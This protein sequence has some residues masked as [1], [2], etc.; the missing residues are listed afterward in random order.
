LQ[1]SQ[2]TI[3]KQLSAPDLG[4]SV[5]TAQASRQLRSQLHEHFGFRRFRPGQAEAI[6]SAMAGNDTLVIM[7]TGSGKSLCFQLPALTLE[8]HTVVVS[9]LIA[10]MKDQADAL[11]ERGISVAVMNSTLSVAEE[12]EANENI[13][14]GRYEFIYTTPERLA[15]R[16]F[17]SLLARHPIDLFVVDEAHCVSQWGHSFRPEYLLIGDAIKHLG[18][19]PVL[20]LTATAT[21]EVI[22]DIQTQLGIPSAEIVHTGFYRSNLNLSVVHASGDDEKQRHLLELLANNDGSG[23]IYT[24]TV[25]AVE[26]LTTALSEQGFAV[27]AYHGRLAARKRTAAQDRFMN[28]E[29]KAIVATNAFGLGIDKPDIRFVIHYHFPGTI[30]AFYQEFGRAGRDGL[31]ANCTL[32]YDEHDRRLQ[33]FFQAGAYPREDDLVNAHHALALLS[34]KA[35]ELSLKDIHAGS[36]LSCSKMKVCLALFVNR[37]IVA[38]AARGKYRLVQRE[39]TREQLARAGQSYQERRERDLLRLEQMMQYSTA[40]ACRWNRILDYF[41][42]GVLSGDSCGHCDRCK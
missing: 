9:P 1:Y 34:D 35:T 2:V 41:D 18:H 23:I 10:L 5:A 21:S 28:G 30:D 11:R 16:E 25:K 15:S 36:P 20:A 37:G 39:M 27:D 19:P 12:K 14:A 7:P 17:Q 33:R 38:Q 4:D 32:L 6:E 29:L 42:S 3:A 40:S 13:A 26:Q 31:P 8:G 22:D 24:A